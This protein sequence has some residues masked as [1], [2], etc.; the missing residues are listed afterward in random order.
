MYADLQT[1]VAFSKERKCHSGGLGR[2]ESAHRDDTDVI[3][4]FVTGAAYF[5]HTG[6]IGLTGKSFIKRSSKSVHMCIYI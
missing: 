3:S 4:S 1:T 6:F 2:A 5:A